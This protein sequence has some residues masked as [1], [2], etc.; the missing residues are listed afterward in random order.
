M[1]N[2]LPTF[3]EIVVVRMRPQGVHFATEID[4]AKFHHIYCVQKKVVCIR[5]EDV[6]PRIISS[7]KVLYRYR[8][9]PSEIIPT[10]AN[11]DITINA[12]FTQNTSDDE[13]NINIETAKLKITKKLKRKI[14][15]IEKLRKFQDY[16]KKS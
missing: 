8:G 9:D 2:F 13:L 11:T 4:A 3:I 10:N 14:K 1:A 6:I 5:I 12:S 16:K 15:E 7:T